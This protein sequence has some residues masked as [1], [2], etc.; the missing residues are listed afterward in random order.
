[1]QLFEITGQNVD[2]LP[3]LIQSSVSKI[4]K[5]PNVTKSLVCIDENQQSHLVIFFAHTKTP[6]KCTTVLSKINNNFFGL[7]QM[8]YTPANKKMTLSLFAK[9]HLMN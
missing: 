6:P 9:K 4:M 5:I 8:E 2:Q 7:S 1:M 3:Q